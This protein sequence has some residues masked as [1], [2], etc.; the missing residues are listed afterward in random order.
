MENEILEILKSIQLDIKELK[1]NQKEIYNTVR[2]LEN[3]SEV[4]KIQ[5]NKVREDKL[6]LEVMQSD[7]NIVKI[8][9]VLQQDLKDTEFKTWIEPNLRRAYIEGESIIIPCDNPFSKDILEK[10]Y[11]NIIREVS[12]LNAVLII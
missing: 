2:T 11:V 5:N 3:S 9:K 4:S 12:G 1:E 7:K 6:N 8:I 10:R